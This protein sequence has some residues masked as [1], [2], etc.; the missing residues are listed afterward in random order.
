M[1]NIV[2]LILDGWGTGKQVQS[3]PFYQVATPT[4]D[5]LKVNF[6]YM[7]LQASGIAVGLPWGD[8]GSSEIGHLTIGSGRILYQ[9]YPR[10]TL[11]I[12]DKTFFANEIS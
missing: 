2:L 9:N 12:R 8:P 1:N 10:I 6:P 11:A 4:F 7:N 3:N 5:W